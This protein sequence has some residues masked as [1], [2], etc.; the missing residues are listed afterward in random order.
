MRHAKGGL[1]GHLMQ[2]SLVLIAF[3]QCLLM[4]QGCQSAYYSTMEK[5]GLEKRDILVDRVD[6]AREAQSEASEQFESAL[7]AFTA[8][9]Q[10]EGGELNEQYQTLKKTFER[11]QQKAEL[12]T[13]RIDGVERVGEDLFQEWGEEIEQYTN[14]NLKQRSQTQLRQTRDRYTRLLAAMRSAENRIPPVLAAFQDRVL[15]LKHNLNAQALSDLKNDVVEVQSDVT[16]LV[17][18]MNRAI[19]QADAFIAQMQ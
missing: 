9:T 2:R 16:A 18:E 13:E 19:G 12:V 17:A 11:S 5:F 6:D 7:E 3:F 8:L 15:F 10:Y 14:E 4:L 1:T